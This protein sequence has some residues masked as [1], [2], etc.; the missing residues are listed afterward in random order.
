MEAYTAGL[1]REAEA[2]AAA[3]AHTAGLRREAEAVAAAEAHTAGLD[4]VEWTEETE[5]QSSAH[6]AIAQHSAPLEHLLVQCQ[7]LAARSRILL[8]SVHALQHGQQLDPPSKTR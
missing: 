7:L 5:G 2:S 4:W 3:D 1:R 6:L 8:A